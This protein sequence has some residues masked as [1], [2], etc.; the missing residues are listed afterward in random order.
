ML[1]SYNGIKYIKEQLDSI[2]NQTYKVDEIIVSDD[3][4]SDGTFE[5]LKEYADSCNDVPIKV[6]HNEGK[7]GPTKNFENAFNYSTADILFFSDQDDVWKKDKVEIFMKAYEKYPDCACIFSNADVVDSTLKPIGKTNFDCFFSDAKML[8]Y[9]GD[10]MALLNQGYVAR[11]ILDGNIIPGMS[12][13]V[14]YSVL[15]KAIRFFDWSWDDA[16]VMYCAINEHMAAIN[17]TLCLYRQHENNLVGIG[18]VQRVDDKRSI[19]EYKK[20]FIS[21]LKQLNYQYQRSQVYQDVDIEHK[22][23]FIE[24][25]KY[26]EA[27][28]YKAAQCVRIVALLKYII[29]FFRRLYDRAHGKKLFLLDCATCLFVSKRER[30]S[31]F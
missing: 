15:K 8:N 21:D 25:K 16:I 27:M 13:S 14:K 23:E 29:L 26:F 20:R 12:M 17:M 28:R 18:K 24:K 10:S 1:A 19:S 4:S 3:G 7:H 5:F 2:V 22:Y 6:V 9:D 31:Y 30:I 11:R